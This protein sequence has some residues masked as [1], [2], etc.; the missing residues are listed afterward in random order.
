MLE[1]QEIQVFKRNLEA[2][3]QGQARGFLRFF[4]RMAAMEQI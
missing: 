4:S 1:E 2:R 3:P